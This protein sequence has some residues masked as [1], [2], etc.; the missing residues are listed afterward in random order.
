ML[1]ATFLRSLAC[2]ARKKRV[3]NKKRN[4]NQCYVRC[5]VESRGYKRMDER[6]SAVMNRVC[7]VSVPNNGA[8]LL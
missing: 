4:E 2:C 3:R 1:F 6:E 5:G 7:V 8:M